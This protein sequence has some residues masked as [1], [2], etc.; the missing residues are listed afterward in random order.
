M[1]IPT[2]HGRPLVD[3]LYH[4]AAPPDAIARLTINRP[5]VRNAFRPET[6]AEL[7]A[8]LADARDDG[9]I[10]TIILTG[11]GTEAF[12]SGGDQGARGHA[13]YVGPDGVPRL[14][15]LDLQTQIRRTPKP[16]VAMVAGYAVGGG[17]V[18]QVCC[19]LAIAAG[20]AVFGQ[21]GPRVGSFDAGYGASALARLVGQRKAREIWFLARLYGAAEAQAMGL[22]NA[23]VP[24]SDLEATTVAWCREMGR[25][26]PT[27]LRVMKAALNA[28]DDG[29]AGLQELGGN[30]TLLFYQTEE[31]SEVR[32]R[33]RGWRERGMEGER[34]TRTRAPVFASLTRLSHSLSS[35]DRARTRSWRSGRPTLPASPAC[36]EHTR[37]RDRLYKKTRPT[38]FPFFSPLTPPPPARPGGPPPPGPPP[39]PPPGPAGPPPPPGLQRRARWA[40]SPRPGRPGGGR[41]G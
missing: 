22:V 1:P 28:V 18:L 11:S 17:H 19:D 5:A 10:A 35:H 21:T 30:A 7:A 4:K 37:K 24:L 33:E 15:V 20:N 3:I 38:L 36:R 25:N 34:G 2:L 40:P 9:A 13:G 39:P 41:R 26:S 27:A 29:G 8:A 31:G 16:V 23:V 6:V 12:C 14:N 32:E